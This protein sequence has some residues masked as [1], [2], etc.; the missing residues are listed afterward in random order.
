MTAAAAAAAA[1]TATSVTRVPERRHTDSG[2]CRLLKHCTPFHPVS[3]PP[4]ASTNQA[5]AKAQGAL[6]D[7]ERRKGE[8]HKSAAA[9]A[10]DFQQAC[11]F[12][13]AD[14]GTNGW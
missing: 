11:G 4:L 3:L 2:V 9:A 6:A 1:A 8:A 12:V 5:A 14:A 7:L 10:A 13:C